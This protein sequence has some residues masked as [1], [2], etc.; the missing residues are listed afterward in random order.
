LYR[1]KFTHSQAIPDES[2]QP[3]PVPT[4][5]PEIPMRKPSLRPSRLRPLLAP[6]LAALLTGCPGEVPRE[7]GGTGATDAGAVPAS[8]GESSE[9]NADL[10]LHTVAEGEQ[11]DV[12]FVT[13]G[14]A[15]FWVIAEAGARN[16]GEEFDAHVEVRMPPEGAPDQQ[17]MLEELLATGIDGIAVSPIDAENQA[18]FLNDVAESTNLIIHDSDAPNTNRICY[19]G[20]S[21][22]DAGRLCGELVKAALPDGGS[23]M[24]FVGRMEQDNA[25]GRRQGLIDEL[26]DRPHDPTRFDDTEQ[27][28]PG[29]KYTILGTRTDKFNFQDCKAQ[30]EDAL[31]AHPDIGAMVGLFAY[32]PPMILEAL[33]GAGKLGEVQ[34]IGFDEADETLQ[35][36]IDGHCYGTVVQNPYRYGYESVRILAGLAR[37]DQSVI[38]DGGFLDIPAR[39]ITKENVDSF[40]TELKALVE[41]K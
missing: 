27:V 22:Y 5:I 8:G 24:I 21:N 25:R 40:W 38:P 31:S 36:I 12:A 29:D 41:S 1:E 26:L 6:L 37:G 2:D 19:V 34:V 30:A 32:N 15:S 7:G 17:R 20:M 39:K 33:K 3:F 16:A 23:L 13:N 14:I 35:A 4:T 11:P 18:S 28:I 9:S 10:E